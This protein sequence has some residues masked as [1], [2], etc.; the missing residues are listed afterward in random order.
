MPE[1]A[2]VLDQNAND[3]IE[4]AQPVIETPVAEP[5]K[6][7]SKQEKVDRPTWS[8]PVAK[9]QE[10]KRK[11]VEKARLEAIEEK[12]REIE[13]MREEYEKRLSAV[14]PIESDIERIASEHGLESKAV[15]DLYEV[16]EKRVAGKIP[17]MSKYDEIV[18]QKELENH[19]LAVEREFD[20]KVAPLLLKD[21][22]AATPQHLIDARKK[23]T[24][25]AFTDGFNTYRIEDIYKVNRE[26]FEYKNGYSA[27]SSGGRSSE[28]VDFDTMTDEEEHELAQKNPEKYKEFLKWQVSTK[29]S[30]YQN[31]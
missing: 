16:F 12:D 20:E 18:K 31:I 8:M 15:N 7:E 29:G 6:E 3:P 23:L 28:L 19:R 14:K 30:L 27:E 25:L 9:A 4:G 21:F 11:A 5:P 1:G 17:D 26:E 2:E 13:R 24:D 10:E 22:P